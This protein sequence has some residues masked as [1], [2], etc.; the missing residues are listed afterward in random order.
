MRDPGVLMYLQYGV[1]ACSLLIRSCRVRLLHHRVVLFHTCPVRLLLLLL[2]LTSFISKGSYVSIEVGKSTLATI[3]LKGRKITER[4]IKDK[5]SL[6]EMI[7]NWCDS[8][9][10][11]PARSPRAGAQTSSPRHLSILP[12]LQLK[13]MKRTMICFL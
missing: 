13:A 4:E 2:L 10:R 11:I 9:V 1:S 12:V 5:Y 6:E 3:M 7:L 8:R